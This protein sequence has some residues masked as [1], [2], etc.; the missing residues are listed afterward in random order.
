MKPILLLS[1]EHGVN[2]LPPAYANHFAPH[3]ALLQTHRAFDFGAL[4]IAKRLSQLFNCT[5]IQAQATRLLVDC[6]RSLSHPHCFSE[7]S[8]WLSADEKKALAHEYY[9]PFRQEVEQL[10]KIAIAQG[11][12]VCHFSIHSFTPSLNGLLRNADIGLLYDPQRV[13]EKML[14]KHWQQQL[15]Q[16][17]PKLRVRL[18]YPYR[19]I[20]DGFTAALRRQFSENEYLGIEVES[21]QAIVAEE[22]GLDNFAEVLAITLKK[23]LE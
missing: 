17:G 6:N 12:Q 9:L 18:N 3:T 4:A 11:Q 19:G 20:S 15:K 7:I 21:N 10:I 16:S 14:A 13:G 23:C 8:K 2:T 1:C 22:K 5:L